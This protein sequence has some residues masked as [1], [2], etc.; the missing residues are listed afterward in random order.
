MMVNYYTW[1]DL[2]KMNIRDEGGHWKEKVSVFHSF[3]NAGKDLYHAVITQC[4]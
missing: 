4:H 2:K 1:H 3:N